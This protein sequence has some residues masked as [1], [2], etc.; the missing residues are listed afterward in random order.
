M[1]RVSDF[2]ES[3]R[4]VLAQKYHFT[5]E[6]KVST[7]EP[8][9]VFF[10]DDQIVGFSKIAFTGDCPELTEFMLEDKLYRTDGLFFM[11]VICAKIMDLGYEYL[12][13]NTVN[14]GD[15][16]KGEKILFD[17]FLKGC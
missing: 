9:Y 11:K 6:K 1:I 13:N 4:E 7:F 17:K 10:E 5:Y 15:F 2:K 8:V 12:I 3:Y 14:F 16:Q